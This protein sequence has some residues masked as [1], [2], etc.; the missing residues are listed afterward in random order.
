M[1]VTRGESAHQDIGRKPVELPLAF[2][3]LVIQSC[4]NGRKRRNTATLVHRF[5]LSVFCIDSL[6]RLLFGREFIFHFIDLRL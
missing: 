3:M 1:Q 4:G 6:Y 2:D 5:V